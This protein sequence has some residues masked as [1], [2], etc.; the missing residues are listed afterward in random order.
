MSD[1]SSMLRSDEPVRVV[2]K[3]NDGEPLIGIDKKEMTVIVTDMNTPACRAIRDAADDEAAEND[4]RLSIAKREAF[5]LDVLAAATVGAEALAWDDK[6]YEYSK[7][8]MRKLYKKS[9]VI[10]RQVDKIV[11]ANKYFTE[12]ARDQDGE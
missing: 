6:P 2:L 7:K 3:G 4:G 1:L 5:G 11:G 10:R 8:N 9:P 12:G